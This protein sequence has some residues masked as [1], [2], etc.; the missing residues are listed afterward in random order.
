MDHYCQAF[1][2]PDNVI[3][4]YT[5][6]IKHRIDLI[7][8]APFIQRRPSRIPPAMHEEVQKQVA[9]MLKQRIIEPSDSPFCSPICMVPKKGGKSWRFAVDY[10]GINGITKKSVYFL[11]LI[12][13][14]VDLMGTHKYYSVFDLCAAYHQVD[15]LPEHAER[16]AFAVFGT[17]Y[18]FLRL[19]FGLCAAPATFQKIMDGLRRELSSCSFCYLDDFVIGSSDE[20]SHLADIEEFMRTLVKYGLKLKAEKCE[21]GKD[22]IKYLGFLI[23]EAGIRP[24]PKNIDKIRDFQPPKT[25][26]ELKSFIGAMQFFSQVYSEFLGHYCTTDFAHANRE[27]EHCRELDSRMPKGFRRD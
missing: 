5:G 24:D 26:T 15:M 9:D 21:F 18:H 14:L 7:D 11:P 8:N 27:H 13:E 19:P 12:Q 1:V 4:H 2:G 10:R 3:G 23:S 16:T 25:Q 20:E 6:P 17:L 22:E